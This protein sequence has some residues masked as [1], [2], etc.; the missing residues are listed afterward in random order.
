MP[1]FPLIQA[2]RVRHPGWA[3]GGLIERKETYD[4]LPVCIMPDR[5]NIPENTLRP[6]LVPAE[7]LRIQS[8]EGPYKSAPDTTRKYHPN[9]GS[10]T[11]LWTTYLSL[12]TG[13]PIMKT[14][15]LHGR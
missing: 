10:G 6:N 3:P 13:I 5:Q 1:R 4:E 15:R 12:C 8:W 14:F 7:L 11:S 2:I 9:M